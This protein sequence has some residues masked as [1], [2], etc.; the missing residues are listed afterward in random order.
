MRRRERR[1]MQ[2]LGFLIAGLGIGAGLLLAPRS[3]RELRAGIGRG[4]RKTKKKIIRQAE[5][6]QDSSEDLMERAR[7]LQKRAL[8]MSK[9]GIK[10]V[11]NYRAA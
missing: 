6:W 4:F 10:A 8:M 2:G 9:R 5:S 3:G 7:R 11:R 1:T